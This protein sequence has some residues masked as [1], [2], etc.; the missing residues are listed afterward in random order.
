MWA[1]VS[2]RAKY[3]CSNSNQSLEFVGKQ[4]H[5]VFVQWISRVCVLEGFLFNNRN[6][7]QEFVPSQNPGSIA[8]HGVISPRKI[9]WHCFAPK[10]ESQVLVCA[11]LDPCYV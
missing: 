6:K 3:R 1:S 8:V 7:Q 4:H 11:F 5:Y 9:N 2:K 10:F